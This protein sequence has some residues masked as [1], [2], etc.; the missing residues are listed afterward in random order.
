MPVNAS[1]TILIAALEELAIQVGL[2]NPAV[3]RTKDCIHD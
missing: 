2:G 1:P 3:G